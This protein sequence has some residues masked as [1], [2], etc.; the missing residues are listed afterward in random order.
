MT[1]NKGSSQPKRTII[2]G[3]PMEKNRNVKRTIIKIIGFM[4]IAFFRSIATRYLVCLLIMRGKLQ[5]LAN[6]N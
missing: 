3:S 6:Q 4:I 2:M 5:H 1:E